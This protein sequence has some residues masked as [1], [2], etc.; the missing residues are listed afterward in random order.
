MRGR[1]DRGGE[2]G[3]VA[4]GEL[5]EEAIADLHVDARDRA[6]L[7]VGDRR[8][9][10]GEHRHVAVD[11]AGDGDGEAE[12]ARGKAAEALREERGRTADR[13][14]RSSPRRVRRRRHGGGEEAR[15]RGHGR[16]GRRAGACIGT[17][18]RA[19]AAGWTERRE[20]GGEEQ[21]QDR[22]S[23]LPQPAFD[24]RG[25]FDRR[26][27]EANLTPDLDHPGVVSYHLRA[28]A[29]RDGGRR[30]SC[31]SGPFAAVRAPGWEVF[32]RRRHHRVRWMSGR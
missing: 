14:A 10:H 4:A 6:E 25:E 29:P 22:S 26:S 18:A 20:C 21:H 7:A 24:P 16:Q 19:R 23:A 15:R 5:I 30:L 8:G 1:V 27:A 12:A 2:A 11:L 31:A 9:D 3:R 13:R 28:S 32:R 17:H